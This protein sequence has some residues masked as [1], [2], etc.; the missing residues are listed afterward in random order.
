MVENNLLN[1]YKSCTMLK[2]SFLEIIKKIENEET[3]HAVCDDYSFSIKIEDYVPYVAVALHDG[4]QIRKDIC[5][6][7]LLTDRKRSLQEDAYTA[8]MIKDLPI[9]II[10]HDSKFEYDLDEHPRQAIRLESNGM[11]VWSPE[12]SNDDKANSLEKHNRFYRVVLNLLIKLEELY[13]N[14]IFYDIHARSDNGAN[15]VF[16]I[17][18]KNLDMT[19]YNNAVAQWQEILLKMALPIQREITCETTEEMHSNGFFAHYIKENS[20]SSVAIST[21]IT[22]VFCDENAGILFPEVLEAIRSQFKYY[23][24]AHAHRFYDVYHPVEDPFE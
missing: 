22:K 4:H 7:F 20:L 6:K 9:T 10:A 5:D 11:G 12:L 15:P 18:V 19:V 8:A 14:T 13:G 23:I 21:Y 24:K 1:P 3:F 17:G 16:A 2:L